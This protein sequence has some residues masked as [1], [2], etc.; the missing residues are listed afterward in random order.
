MKLSQ[1]LVVP[2][3]RL[4]CSKVHRGSAVPLSPKW[5]LT[6]RHVIGPEAYA[7]RQNKG[8]IVRLD[9]RNGPYL[10]AG[11]IPITT[12]YED[13]KIDLAVCETKEPIC[14]SGLNL[15]VSWQMPRIFAYG[16]TE[17]FPCKVSW[18]GPVIPK[19]IQSVEDKPTHLVA[20]FGLPEGFSGGPWIAYCNQVPHV[21][22]VSARGGSGRAVSQAFAA[23][24][25]IAFLQTVQHHFGPG[26]M[27]WKTTDPVL[28]FYGSKL[29][30]WVEHQ[31]QGF[32]SQLRDPSFLWNIH[33]R[34]PK[35]QNELVWLE[36]ITQKALA[37]LRLGRLPQYVCFFIDAECLLK[38][39][40]R[41]R[42]SDSLSALAA[43]ICHESSQTVRPMCT[44][45]KQLMVDGRVRWLLFGEQRT[46]GR[47][48]FDQCDINRLFA[49]LDLERRGK[50]SVRRDACGK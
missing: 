3:R 31:K 34:S 36:G 12:I 39:I 4:D 48:V 8:R 17:A 6:C 10:Y 40:K 24:Q 27:S 25:C 46:F 43:F 18:Q 33:P 21:I 42:Y 49:H 16:F 2:I 20:R 7:Q 5:V 28:E 22:G 11:D 35:G 1:T 14:S 13:L 15:A 32:S 9:L 26:D 50:N 29:A 44:L 47:N 23:L 45:V 19:A 41:G 37:A 30:H 38:F